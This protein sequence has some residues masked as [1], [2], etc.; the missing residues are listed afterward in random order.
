MSDTITLKENIV[1]PQRIGT[2]SEAD[3]RTLLE[4]G[5]IDLRTGVYAKVVDVDASGTVR[6]DDGYYV[7]PRNFRF[8]DVVPAR[9]EDGGNK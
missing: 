4:S 6:L 1:A 2:A 3:K 9:P 8:Y 5:L 7:P